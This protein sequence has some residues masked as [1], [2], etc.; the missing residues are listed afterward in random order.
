MSLLCIDNGTLHKIDNNLFGI[1]TN[2][3]LRELGIEDIIGDL[4]NDI[5]YLKM[6]DGQLIHIQVP[7]N[8]EHLQGAINY[9]LKQEG[10]PEWNIQKIINFFDAHFE[11]IVLEINR[12]RRLE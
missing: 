6:F 1:K 7:G 2:F 11:E 9:D 12:L 8:L 3:S 4:V 10:I 5:I